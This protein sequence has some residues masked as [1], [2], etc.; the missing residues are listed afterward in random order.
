VLTDPKV[1]EGLIV[2]FWE[3]ESETEASETNSL[4]IGQMSMMSSFLWAAGA[5]D[6]RGQHPGVGKP[7]L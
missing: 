5:Q 1:G 6:L 7:F 2:S 3:T 4:Y